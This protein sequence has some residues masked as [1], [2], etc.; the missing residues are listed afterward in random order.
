M[1]FEGAVLHVWLLLGLFFFASL[2]AFDVNFQ[3]LKCCIALPYHQL[4][5]H[6]F[7][8]YTWPG[9]LHSTI[10]MLVVSLFRRNDMFVFH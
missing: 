10:I 6:I 5:H 3:Q 4:I 1:A 2:K 9:T 8:I 7:A